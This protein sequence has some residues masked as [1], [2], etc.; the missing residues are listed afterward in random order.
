M[1]WPRHAR[2]RSTPVAA[3]WSPAMRRPGG[4]RCSTRC[5]GSVT[6]LRRR[7][8]I[9]GGA[10][11]EVEADLRFRHEHDGVLAITVVED[12]ALHVK[13]EP[14]LDVLAP[15]VLCL[16]G[17]LAEDRLVQG[18]QPLLAVEDQPIG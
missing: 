9:Q 18:S 4:S 3:R 2:L 7:R 8:E 12:S 5:R 1:R 10:G 16:D 14:S 17:G 6:F 11:A 15:D 13:V